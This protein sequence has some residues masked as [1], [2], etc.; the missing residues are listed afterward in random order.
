MGRRKLGEHAHLPARICYKHGAYYHAYKE[1]GKNKWT[2]LDRDYLS[3][4]RRYSE[5][6]AE[7]D[8]VLL[9]KSSNWIDLFYKNVKARAKVRRFECTITR[10]DIASL[11]ERSEGK[12]AITG[13]KFEFGGKGKPSPWAPS[14]DCIDSNL[15]YTHGNVRLVC[16]AV[17]YA[18][19]KW[20]TD[21]LMRMAQAI[22]QQRYCRHA[23]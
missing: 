17:N 9:L 12:C 15:G 16:L 6:E 2:H 22:C 4:L 10:D 20:G 13:I 14:L 8:P 3:A 11:T 5:L 23:A 21:V 1:G 18:K 7:R 19:N